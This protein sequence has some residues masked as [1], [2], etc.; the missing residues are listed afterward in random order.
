MRVI[1]GDATRLPLADESVA[2]IVTSPPY[3]VGMEY[4]D[5]A[6]DVMSWKDY[7]A[8]ARDSAREMFRVLKPGGRVWVDIQPTVPYGPGDNTR[9]AALVSIWDDWLRAPGFLYRDTVAWIQDSHDG[10]CAW[11]SWLLPSAP[12]QRGGWESILCFYKDTW[13]RKRPDGVSPTWRAPRFDLGGD[14][15]ND[16]CRNTWKIA[17]SRSKYPATFP[18]DLPARCIRLSTWPGETVLDPF[19]GTG[20]TADAAER[21]GRHGITVSLDAAGTAFARDRAERLVEAR[22]VGAALRWPGGEISQK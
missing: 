13:T 2:C 5:D 8:L 21:L 18:I 10:Q 14:W 22:A 7:G 12:N 4:G 1:Q 11:G 3:N 19:G 6:P 16:L 9:R 15:G 17:P 20:T